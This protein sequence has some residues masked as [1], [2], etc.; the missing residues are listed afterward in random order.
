MYTVITSKVQKTHDQ[1]KRAPQ[2]KLRMKRRILGARRKNVPMRFKDLDD[3]IDK[4][5]YFK[6]VRSEFDQ[7]IEQEVLKVMK[8]TR[9]PKNCEVGELSLLFTKKRSGKLKAR[10]VF[11]ER[12]QK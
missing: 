7:M 5:R 9:I 2:Q 11:N 10:L 6:A 4:E 8:R 3:H 12:K 1:K